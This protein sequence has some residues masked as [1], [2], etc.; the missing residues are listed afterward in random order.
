MKLY[1]TRK[2][3]NVGVPMD[4]CKCPV[5]RSANRAA[6]R[7]GYREACVGSGTIYFEAGLQSYQIGVPGKVILFIRNFDMGTLHGFKPFSFEVPDIP[8]LTA[9]NPG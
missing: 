1:I 6:K 2:D 7:Y 9:G 4:C 3:V 5:G 8:D